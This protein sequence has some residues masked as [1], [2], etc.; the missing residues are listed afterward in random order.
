MFFLCL[1]KIAFSY[2]YSFFPGTPPHIFFK[3]LE[4]NDSVLID[5]LSISFYISYYTSSK[6]L[7]KKYNTDPNFTNFQLLYET[8]IYSSTHFDHVENIPTRFI[9]II[10]EKGYFYF[11]IGSLDKFLCDKV[12]LDTHLNNSYIFNLE[13]NS[14]FSLPIKEKRCYFIGTPGYQSISAFMGECDNCPLID[15]YTGNKKILGSITKNLHVHLINPY[16]NIPLLIIIYPSINKPSIVQN[17]TFFI[18]SN[19][20]H[21][22]EPISI[23]FNEY[24][25]NNNSNYDQNDFMVNNFAFIIIFL[26]IVFILIMIFIIFIEEEKLLLKSTIPNH[27]IISIET[28]EHETQYTIEIFKKLIK[29]NS[30][31]YS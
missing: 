3:Y 4:P 24:R 29:E 14:I 30:K 9:F 15:V 20:S 26:L 11:S 31:E 1:N 5:V 19:I 6:V 28:I 18:S 25:N 22:Y 10:L 27:S 12:F 17:L 23:E 13:G 2:S 7:I 21:F 8:I 16:F